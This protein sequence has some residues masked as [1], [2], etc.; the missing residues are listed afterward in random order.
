MGGQGRRE[1]SIDAAQAQ[2]ATQERKSF[3]AAFATKL[4]NLT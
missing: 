2:W 3:A 4:S 1:T